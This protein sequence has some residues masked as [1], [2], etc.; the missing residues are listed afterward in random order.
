MYVKKSL[1]TRQG[2]NTV[3]RDP[4]T[5]RVVSHTARP[6]LVKLSK[7]WRHGIVELTKNG[8]PIL[9]RL[10]ETAMGKSVV[11]VNAD[12]G[13]E[14]VFP[15]HDAMNKAAIDLLNRI[16]GVP[17]R[18][19]EVHKVEADEKRRAA[20]E[21]MSEEQ[22]EKIIDGEYTVVNDSTEGGDAE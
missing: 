3:L 17:V 5:N 6:V 4:E 1:I 21:A 20:L 2:G 14:E 15:S 18:Q 11:R 13:Q 8:L 10:Y 22:L 7:T 16:H 12:G 19:D 9:E